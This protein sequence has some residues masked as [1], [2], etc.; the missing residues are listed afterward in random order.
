MRRLAAAATIA[1]AAVGAGACA[2]NTSKNAAAVSSPAAGD[3]TTTSSTIAFGATHRVQLTKLTFVDKTRATNDPDNVRSAPTRTLVTWVWVPR[4]NGPFPLIV[5]AHG[6]N[7]HPRK[8]T[9]LLGGWARHGFVVAAPAFPLSNDESGGPVVIGDYPNQALD[10]RFV[11]RQLLAM[12][13]RPGNALSGKID[14]DHVGMSGLSL[15]GATAYGAAFND[16]CRDAHVDAAIIMSGIKLPFDDHQ[17]HFA[18][19]PVLI[20]H[21]TNDPLIPFNTA[22]TAY[23]EAAPPKYFVTLIGAGHAAAYED[24]PDVHDRVVEKV[25]LDFWNVYLR[26]DQRSAKKLLNDAQVPDLASVESQPR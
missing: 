1:L 23:A 3:A 5:H 22:R 6:S 18:G 26:S 20:M 19:T 7:G 25:T 11:L 9:Q 2:G 4:G 8:F 21:G 13:D 14:A 10:M 12:A 15:G 24:T 17:Y 16:C